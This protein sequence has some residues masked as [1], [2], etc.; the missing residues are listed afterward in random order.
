MNYAVEN[1]VSVSGGKDSSSVSFIRSLIFSC[2]LVPLLYQALWNTLGLNKMNG[3]QSLISWT[4]HLPFLCHS[5]L[6]FFF[7]KDFIYL[8]FRGWGREKEVE[9]H[10][11]LTDRLTSYLLHAPN[12]GPGCQPR[13]LKLAD[14][15]ST[16]PHQ[17]GLHFLSK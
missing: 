1:N 6:H 11:C 4:C 3:A 16:E 10:Q 17:P 12:W 13:E 7:F 15:Q 2:L 5:F 9:K 8:L 14:A